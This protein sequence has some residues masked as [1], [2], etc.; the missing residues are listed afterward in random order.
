MS[1][2]REIC[3]RFVQGDL[4]AFEILF[5]RHQGEVFGWIHRIVRNRGEAEDLTVE[6]FWKIYV[7]RARFD[8]RRSFGAWAR[9]IATNLALNR[10]RS[11]RRHEPLVFEP[12]AAATADPVERGELRAE[13]ESALGELS[14]KL[15]L[16]VTLALVEELPYAEIAESLGLSREAVKSRVFRAVRKLRKALA[17]RGIE[18]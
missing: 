4:G 8:E 17:A 13:L 14:P 10:L 18:P 2:E 9:R 6:A 1:D 16:V 11:L 3:E 7:S 5:S 12:P 15:R